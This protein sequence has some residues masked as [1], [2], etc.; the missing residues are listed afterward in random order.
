MP[1]NHL[2]TTPLRQNRDILVVDDDVYLCEIMSDVLQAE[3][4]KTRTASNGLEAL[5]RIREKRPDLILLDLMMPVMSGWELAATLRANSDWND[6][7]IVIITADYHVERKRE[8]T[9]ARAVI[10]KP[11]DIDQL[12][13][14]V[15]TFAT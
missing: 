11:F 6:I 15:D 4:H 13:Q 2:H 12:V 10:T 3:G 14:V 9:G 5:E 8:E 1:S 7:P